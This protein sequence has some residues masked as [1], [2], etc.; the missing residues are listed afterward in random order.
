MNQ[1]LAYLKE[2]TT[3]KKWKAVGS[4]LCYL[5]YYM[6]ALMLG[7]LI[8][9]E[10]KLTSGLL[11]NL[12]VILYLRWSY[13]KKDKKLLTE[14]HWKNFNGKKL[15]FTIILGGGFTLFIQ[16][17]QYLVPASWRDAMTQQNFSAYI[18]QDKIITFGVLVILSPIVEE[19]FFRIY[20]MKKLGE[21]MDFK[22][23]AIVQAAIFGILHF[24]PILSV[25]AFLTGLFYAWINEK[26]DAALSSTIIHIL[27]N[28]L[29]FFTVLNV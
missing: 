16:L 9:P 23:A 11:G 10:S 13:K 15:L 25:M 28:A 26:M 21:A 29:A 7:E 22:E 8:V 4:C 19:L 24:H 20:F 1:I 27:N 3:K 14:F 12:F 18:G 2:E 5:L 17:L 6:L